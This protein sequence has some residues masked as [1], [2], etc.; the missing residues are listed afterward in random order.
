[1]ETNIGALMFSEALWC[2]PHRRAFACGSFIHLR[3]K[4][5]KI[6]A[7]LS[8]GEN[9]HFLRRKW[10]ALFKVLC[11]DP[12]KDI[13]TKRRFFVRGSIRIFAPQVNKIENWQKWRKIAF[14]KSCFFQNFGIFRKNFI[15]LAKNGILGAKSP[16]GSP[17]KWKIR[18]IFW[19][20]YEFV[21]GSIVG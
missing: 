8:I 16:N 10:R 12:L 4:G 21:R 1:M 9:E 6:G 7:S 19:R 2:V 5:P 18:E 17:H 11:G 14:F 3:R 13:P 20:F 15:F